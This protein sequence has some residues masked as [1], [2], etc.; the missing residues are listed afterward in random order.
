MM[1]DSHIHHAPARSLQRRA[2]WFALLL[3]AGYMV[4]EVV[5]GLAFGSLALL[6]DAG[7]MLSDVAALSIA[8]VAHS[9]LDRPSTPRHTYGLQRAEV[10]GALANGVT[11]IAV[12]LWIFVAAAGRLADPP[13]VEGAGVLLIGLVGLDVNIVSAFMLAR[14][15]GTSLNMRGAYLHMAAD[16]LGSVAVIVAAV[17]AIVWDATWVDPAASMVI[18]VLIMWSTLRLLRDT[19]QVLME[20]APRGMNAAEV[21]TAIASH[22]YVESVHHL[23]LWNVA[24]D[25]PALS[26]HVV[27]RDDVSLHEAQQRGDEV[28]RMLNERFGI[29]HST[30]ELECHSCEQEVAEQL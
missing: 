4:A 12:V 1:A 3:N 24:S 14:A 9:L 17:A 11:L 22:R 27:L 13:D 8:L 2:L 5:G 23:H 6:A 20:G 29:E 25:F 10:I 30:L 18:A 19:V 16:A 26:A 7:H 28:K 21:E 15:R